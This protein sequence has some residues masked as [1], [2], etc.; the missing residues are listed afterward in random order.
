MNFA[1][2]WK[3]DNMLHNCVCCGGTK[4][5]STDIRFAIFK[6]T[7]TNHMLSQYGPQA[8]LWSTFTF[9]KENV[10]CIPQGWAFLKLNAGRVFTQITD[11]VGHE[12]LWRHH[13]KYNIIPLLYSY[14]ITATKIWKIC[15]DMFGHKRV[16]YWD[17]Y[18]FTQYFNIE[19]C[20]SSTNNS[21]SLLSSYPFRQ[22]N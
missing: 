19:R 10:G 5:A 20:F 16:Y 14:S 18:Y 12:V 8:S 13:L 1:E 4:P 21:P 9:T 3:C 7:Q 2:F 15:K 22:T 11:A 6:L 17:T